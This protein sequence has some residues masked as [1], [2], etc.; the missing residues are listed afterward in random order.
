AKILLDASLDVPT[1][2]DVLRAV[3]KA[4]GGKVDDVDSAVRDTAST[5]KADPSHA[6][7]ITWI[8]EALGE[9][10]L[11][12]VRAIHKILGISKRP[13][14]LI[15]NDLKLREFTPGVWKRLEESNATAPRLFL[16]GGLPVRVAHIPERRN[17]KKQT[18]VFQA[19]GPD[20]IR[21]EVANV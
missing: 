14:G 15:V 19:A 12:T 7:G 6:L 16:Q 17:D 20:V 1:S 10:G 13:D 2:I 9:A 18:H 3:V 4:T 5:M 8:Q 21:H 11:Q